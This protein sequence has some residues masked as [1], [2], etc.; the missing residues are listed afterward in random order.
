MGL[1]HQMPSD[2]AEAT[3]TEH[4]ARLVTRKLVLADATP[5]VGVASVVSFCGSEDGLMAAASNERPANTQSSRRA[6]IYTGSM[7]GA[8]LLI[9][10][11]AI[12]W[13][14]LHRGQCPESGTLLCRD[15]DRYVLAVGPT[16]L[17]LFGGIGAFVR[18]YQMWNADIRWRP[19]L[20]SG[21]VLFL[22]MTVYMTM[23][24]GVL[25]ER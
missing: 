7:I 21:W 16:V 25:L 10:V 23:S 15:V 9:M 2:V 6:L 18:C 20:A 12:A 19:W 5:N 11:L 1:P 17:L 22:F 24:A 3:H 13:A 8:A 14:G 4:N